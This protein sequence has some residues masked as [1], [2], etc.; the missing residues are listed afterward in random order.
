MLG[1]EYE[2]NGTK[3]TGQVL[4]EE[5]KAIIRRLAEVINKGN[6]DVVDEIFA[7]NYV[8]HDPSDLLREVGREEYKQ[9]FTIDRSEILSI[10]RRARKRYLWFVEIDFYEAVENES[11]SKVSYSVWLILW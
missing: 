2:D 10:F 9:T 4:A 1:V 3:E 11:R 6:L 5:N 8:R 7:P